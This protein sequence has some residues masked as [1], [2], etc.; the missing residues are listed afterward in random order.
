MLFRS[1]DTVSYMDIM[2]LP[3][4]I[5]S[6]EVNELLAPVIEEMSTQVA[7]KIMELNG[8][9]PVSAVFIVGGGGKMAGYAEAVAQKLGIA[10]ER[11]ALRGEE[12]MQNVVFQE[13]IKKDSLLVTPVGICMNY[14]EQNNNFIFVSFNGS[15]IKMYDNN[16]LTVADVVLQAQFQ[17]G[18]AHV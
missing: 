5:R 9:K 12:V 6:E 16:N 13:D 4:T 8:G 14:Y 2:L 17:I 15:R 18:R 1:S 10:K 3:Q 7:D 11:V